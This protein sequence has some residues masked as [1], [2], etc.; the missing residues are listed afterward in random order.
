[1]LPRKRF[2]QVDGEVAA[3]GKIVSIGK[4][5]RT[6]IVQQLLDELTTEELIEMKNEKIKDLKVEHS[7]EDEQVPEKATSNKIKDM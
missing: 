1:M 2:C 6:D 7:L 4:S 3:D 5:M